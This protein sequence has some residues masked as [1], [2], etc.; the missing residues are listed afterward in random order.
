MTRS[1]MIHRNT[2]STRPLLSRL[3]REPVSNGSPLWWRKVLN[4]PKASLYRYHLVSLVASLS[5]LPP[6]QPRTCCF[7]PVPPTKVPISAAVA[8]SL[9]TQTCSRPPMLSPCDP[10]RQGLV[11]SYPGL[12][13]NYPG[14]VLGH[15]CFVLCHSSPTPSMQTLLHT[16]CPCHP[17]SSPC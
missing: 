5:S 12:R 7:N 10:C 2:R 13:P 15:W 16:S 1:G 8:P 14:P 4:T 3:Y 9:A 17:P 11:F 6:P